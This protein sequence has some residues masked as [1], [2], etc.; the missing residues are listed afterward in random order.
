MHNNDT[1]I[2]SNMVKRGLNVN[3]RGT[4]NVVFQAGTLYKIMLH[5]VDV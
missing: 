3:K 4:N 1:V 5:Y 2:H